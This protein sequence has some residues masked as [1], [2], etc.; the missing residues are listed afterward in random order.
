LNNYLPTLNTDGEVKP[1][2]NIDDFDRQNASVSYADLQDYAYLYGSNNFLGSNSFL[3]IFVTSI[4]NI[5]TTTLDYIKNLRSDAQAQIDTKTTLTEVQSNNNTFTGT[6]TFS[7]NIIA[8]STTITPTTLS[9][10]SS[11]SSNAQSQLNNRVTLGSNQTI[12]GVKTIQGNIIADNG[13]FTRTITPTALAFISGLSSDAQTQIDTKTTLSAVQSNNNSWSGTNT[14]NSSLPTSTLTPTTST[15]LV[16]KA[17]AD[18]KTTISAVQ[19][20]NNAWTGTNTFNTSLPTSTLTPSTS[21]QLVTKTYADTKTTLTEVQANNNSFTGTNTFSNTFSTT[22]YSSFYNGNFVVNAGSIGSNKNI[23][24]WGSNVLFYDAATNGTM[25]AVYRD[26]N[27]KNLFIDSSYFNNGVGGGVVFRL[28]NP[29]GTDN[30][31]DVLSVQ[32]LSMTVNQPLTL[33]STLNGISTTTL[34]YL[35]AT[36]SIQ[37]QFNNIGITLSGISYDSSQDITTINNH[38]KLPAGN[39]LLFGDT[40]NVKTNLDD[41]MTKLT[42]VTY[43]STTDIT[44][45][46]NH[47]KLPAGNN[48]LFG[49]T[50]NVKTNLDDCMTKLTG[51]TYNS[52]TD[53]TTIDNTLSVNQTLSVSKNIVANNCFE[54]FDNTVTST[55]FSEQF[56]SGLSADTD[57]ATFTLSEPFTKEL[58]VNLS[59]AGCLFWRNSNTNSNGKIQYT[60]KLS[61]I[62]VYIYK[63]GS[64]W[65]SNVPQYNAD[66]LFSENT[67]RL[68]YS[69]KTENF[70]YFLN[71]SMIK[72]LPD[73]RRNFQSPDVYSIRVTGSIVTSVMHY[74][75]STNTVS[76]YTAGF[77]NYTPCI[78]AN[79]LFSYNGSDS[80]LINMGGVTA[81]T[82]NIV[83]YTHGQYGQSSCVV[84]N[85]VYRLALSSN[86]IKEL[87]CSNT[88]VNTSYANKAIVDT[89]TA[90]NST[91]TNTTVSNSTVTNATITNLNVTNANI[92]NFTGAFNFNKIRGN[93]AAYMFNGTNSLSVVPILCSIKGINPDNADRYFIINPGFYL[94]LYANTWYTGNSQEIVNDGNDPIIYTSTAPNTISS[95]RV[96]FRNNTNETWTYGHEKTYAG[97]SS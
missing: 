60:S 38:V 58:Q 45:I 52:T 84:N 76:T 82:I 6:T 5:A 90:T 33:N 70:Q 3:E 25:T 29:N 80:S 73:I 55:D 94:I 18:T 41:C 72:F 74:T 19:S 20:N 66:K 22:S 56:T 93:V 53:T 17:Y 59:F 36:S 91:L 34:S 67:F 77:L 92:Q 54:T 79:V 43:N 42:G 83:T 48:L 4:N 65:Q 44:T 50:Y 30:Y 31:S 27:T 47:V 63:N 88:C 81:T 40:Y 68:P 95:I 96:Y 46:S 8:N 71:N 97:I 9:Y 87:Q 13:F 89:L 11:L 51:V 69:I 7:N 21:T 64:L 2:F 37:T 78:Y 86:A 32:P 75:I 35:D 23:N 85:D 62:I 26:I 14:F 12:T 49:D 57:L 39:N 24:M 10:I 61:N 28:K 16:T 15:Q 1:V